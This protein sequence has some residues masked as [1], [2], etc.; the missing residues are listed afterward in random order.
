M[1]SGSSSSAF[2]ALENR[3]IVAPSTTLWSAAHDIVMTCAETIASLS[4]PAETRAICGGNVEAK[5]GT[6]LILPI[7][8][9]ATCVEAS[10]IGVCVHAGA[11]ACG[12]HRCNTEPRMLAAHIGFSYN[13]VTHTWGENNTGLA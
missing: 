6:L 9:I 7:A 8:P 5:R 10:N 1:V 12:N 3:A 11:R 4:L 2:Q 13:G